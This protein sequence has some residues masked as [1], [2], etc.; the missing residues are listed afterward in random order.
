MTKAEIIQNWHDW[1]EKFL[2]LQ[3]RERILV[4]LG[5]LALLFLIWDFSFLGPIE[6]KQNA[7][8]ARF[9]RT[10]TELR[11]VAAEEQVL[12]KALTNDPS[13]AAR[14]QILDL[15]NQ[16]SAA[17]KQV[18]SMSAGLISAVRLPEILHDVLQET[19]NLQLVG[20]RHYPAQKLQLAETANDD[21]EAE[22][23]EQDLAIA[24]LQ[25]SDESVASSVDKRLAEE[26]VI[27][28]YKHAVRITL[29]GNYFS[30]VDYL[31]RLEHLKWRFYWD[32]IDYHVDK[33]P[34]AIVTLE[35]Y[36]L[37]TDRGMFGA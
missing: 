7:L 1:E 37:S 13:I 33:Y 16:L 31:Q 11:K 22:P 25:E 23:D 29:Q 2:E 36:T 12:V 30:V 10:T 21:P 14:K 5:V 8:S 32:F 35:V 18:Q 27:G 26:R 34:S 6:K 15:Q 3:L 9:E 4:S 19:G 24:A 20:M 17:D 28:V